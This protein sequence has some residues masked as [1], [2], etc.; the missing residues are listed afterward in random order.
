MISWDGP[1]PHYC[2]TPFRLLVGMLRMESVGLSDDAECPG[3]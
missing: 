3:T 1:T 2:S